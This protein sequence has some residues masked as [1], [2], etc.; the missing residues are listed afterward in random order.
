MANLQQFGRNQSRTIGQTGNQNPCKFVELKQSSHTWGLGAPPSLRLTD[1]KYERERETSVR[2]RPERPQSAERGGLGAGGA[3]RFSRAAGPLTPSQCR[4]RRRR[5][6]QGRR[7]GGG[8]LDLVQ[9]AAAATKVAVAADGRRRRALHI[10]RRAQTAPW[11]S[12]PWVAARSS[13]RWRSGRESS[14]RRGGPGRKC[15]G[16][17][18]REGGGGGQ[19]R[20]GRGGAPRSSVAHSGVTRLKRRPLTARPSFRRR[21][22][23]RL[24]RRARRPPLPSALP[25]RGRQAPTPPGP[26]AAQRTEQGPAAGPSPVPCRPHPDSTRHS[27]SEI[28]GT[29]I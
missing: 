15:A 19:V 16:R 25:V 10:R 24:L 3:A 14:T 8:F 5:R 27:S 26:A 21:T 6:R 2:V 20:P 1:Q 13:P 4:A 18:R 22:H 12:T 7:S 28:K 17:R 11:V 23:R 9:D 29:G